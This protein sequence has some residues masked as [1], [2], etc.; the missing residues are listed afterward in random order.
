MSRM[1]IIKKLRKSTGASI[2]D[3]RDALEQAKR[4]RLAKLANKYKLLLDKI[5]KMSQLELQELVKDIKIKFN[6]VPKEDSK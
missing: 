6:L 4:E 3:C 1:E 2:V 5:D